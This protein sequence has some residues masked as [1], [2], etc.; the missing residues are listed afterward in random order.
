MVPS[1]RSSSWAL[2]GNEEG[3][4]RIQRVGVTLFEQVNKNRTRRIRPRNRHIPRS[5]ELSGERR[6]D[7]M[8]LLSIR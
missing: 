6:M 2:E 7:R 3:N 5:L 1:E 4:G 8:F